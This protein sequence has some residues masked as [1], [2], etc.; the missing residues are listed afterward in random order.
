MEHAYFVSNNL[1]CNCE[2]ISFQWLQEIICAWNCW[3]I[4]AD[5]MMMKWKSLVWDFIEYNMIESYVVYITVTHQD[6]I[7]IYIYIY[8]YIHMYMYIHTYIYI[9]IYTFIFTYICICTYM[10]IFIYMYIYIYTYIHAYT[11]IYTYTYT[12]ITIR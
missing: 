10:H 2:L 5:E 9:C 4:Y 1:I 11:R 8:T 6:T 3:V 7:Y 12:N